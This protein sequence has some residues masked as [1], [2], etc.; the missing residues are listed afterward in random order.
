M[1]GCIKDCDGEL[2]GSLVDPWNGM[3]AEAFN[4][5]RKQ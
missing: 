3:G 5:V 2:E 4:Y 1:D